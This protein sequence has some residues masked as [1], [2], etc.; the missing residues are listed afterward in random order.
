MILSLELDMMMKFN[1]KLMTRSSTYWIDILTTLWDQ[2]IAEDIT[3]ENEL[4]FRQ[5]KSK[6]SIS[7]LFQIVEKSYLFIEVYQYS[8]PC[9]VLSAMYLI[10]RMQ[11]QEQKDKHSEKKIYAKFSEQLSKSSNLIFYDSIGVNELFGDFL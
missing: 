3:Y 9:L 6:R 10:I 11:L 5:E 1:F 7:H 8:V 4:T 2:Y